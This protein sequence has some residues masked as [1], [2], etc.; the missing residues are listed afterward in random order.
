MKTN[1]PCYASL[2]FGV[3]ACMAAGAAGQTVAASTPGLAELSL[4]QLGDLPVTSVSGRPES[5]RSA[6]A[7]VF[8][9]SGEDIRRSGATSL[10][11]ALRLAPNLQVARLSAGQ[12][13]ISAR[14]FN[15]AIANKLL[16]LIDG[17]TIYSTLF[18]GVFWD[19]HDLVLEDIERIEVVSGPGGTLWGAN[20]VNGIINVITRP[21]AATQGA[22]VS[23]TRSRAGGQEA[24]RWGGRVGDL[25]TFR[26]YGLAIDRDNTHTA[27]G[28]EVP[29]AATKHQVGFRT[30]LA[31]GTGQLTL[32]GDAY[33]GGDEPAN[34]FAPTMHGG[35]LLA[36]WEN[37]FADGSPYR[38]QAY[39]DVQAR[40]DVNLF[41]NHM[42]SWDL[43]FT[44]EP[45]LR[46]GHQLLWGG[47]VRTARDESEP[48]PV[49]RF[50]PASRRLNW[51][52]LFAQH[53]V[54]KGPWQFT[55]GVK[56]ERNSYTGV[57]WL[58]NLRAAYE[59]ANH[60]TT[61]AALSR[62]VRAPA[63]IDREFF[64][65]ANPPFIIAGGEGFQS[66]IARVA[67]IGHRGQAGSD[68]SYSGTVF[69]QRYTGLRGGRDFPV[70]IANRIEGDVKGLEAWAQWQPT[71]ASR[72]TLGYLRLH[73]DLRF[74]APPA[75]ATSIANLGDDPRSQWSLRAQFDLPQR[76][77]LDL[78]LRRVGALPAPAVP[79]YTA[80]DARLGWQ[81]T[82]SLELSLIAQNLGSRHVEFGDPATA[83]K[84]GR[85]VFVRV[86]WQ[87]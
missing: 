32:Q 56:A 39:Y 81:V 3:L 19:F 47:G 76:T 54:Q 15:N 9:I 55:A 45:Q 6:P 46:A 34:N 18:S 71:R 53:Q 49:V 36:R 35:N 48:S 83:S 43:Q 5:L 33:R 25:G 13:A 22:L 42:A 16:V 52:N 51:W 58:P 65:P 29:D 79:A 26:V 21:A 23:V 44:H 7:S 69:L 60:A 63:R 72:L 80:L 85:R 10:P 67:E 57:E 41:R 4:E 75:D 8:V 24:L 86:V 31:L 27:S 11:E 1:I 20:A 82:P 40:D 74:S 17:R 37:R 50:I 73:K 30:D 59:H 38:V 62:T 14:G 68:L 84:F 77:E 78:Q 61:W 12:Y 66:E 2:A 70:V 28:S 87:P 64:L